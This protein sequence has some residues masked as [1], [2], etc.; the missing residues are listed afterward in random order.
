VFTVIVL[1]LFFILASSL[2][3]SITAA[4]TRLQMLYNGEAQKQTML[5]RY[6]TDRDISS[7]LRIRVQRN[8]Q[9]ALGLRE[10]NMP[11]SAVELL[12]LISEPLR[13]EIHFEVHSV[14]L[15]KHPFFEKYEVLHP[16]GLRK[17]CHI[18][19][20]PFHV[21]A[22]DI[23][24]S[25]QETPPE[26]RMCFVL[27]G[28][29]RYQPQDDR[30]SQRVARNTWLSEACLW[31]IWQ[32][33]GTLRAASECQL[34]RISA[35]KFQDTCTAF[36]DD[37]VVS[38]AEAYV[39]WLNAIVMRSDVGSITQ[40]RE[41]VEL[42]FPEVEES[43]SSDDEPPRHS[44]SSFAMKRARSGSTFSGNGRTTRAK[45]SMRRRKSGTDLTK[46]TR[47]AWGAR[48]VFWIREKLQ[49]LFRIGGQSDSVVPVVAVRSPS[50][51]FTQSAG[52]RG[53]T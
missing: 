16:M 23:M 43:E 41:L 45:T 18:A 28:T 20:E 13:V 37:H 53:D 1:L 6:L 26:P 12:T 8:A 14:T 44:G 40:A 7:A 36:I 39:E 3:S 34:L 49:I 47:G 19:V 42:A 50:L 32:H 15:K 25:A 27:Q 29:L 46:G 9:H 30:D 31:T 4:M 10:R 24:F 22:G 38:Y 48:S 11:E 17:I 21:S 2:V 51:E 35:T 5:K 33:M 52:S